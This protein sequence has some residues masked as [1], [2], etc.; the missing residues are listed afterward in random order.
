M[1]LFLLFFWE[2]SKNENEL[3]T[4]TPAREEFFGPSEYQKQTPTNYSHTDSEPWSF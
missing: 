4:V 1:I 3:K 2:L